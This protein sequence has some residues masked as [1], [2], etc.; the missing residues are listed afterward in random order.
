MGLYTF[1]S[2]V[3]TLNNE[4][5]QLPYYTDEET[6][7]CPKPQNKSMEVSELESKSS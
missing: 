3:Q 2:T 6:E 5:S 7:T 4:S 1:P